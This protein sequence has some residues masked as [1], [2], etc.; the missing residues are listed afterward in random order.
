MIWLH[1]QKSPRPGKTTRQQGFSYS[2]REVDLVN[3]LPVHFISHLGSFLV[4]FLSPRVPPRSQLSSSSARG[5]PCVL[6]YSHTE[7]LAIVLVPV[8]FD[9]DILILTS[10]EHPH[11]DPAC[12]SLVCGARMPSL[13]LCSLIP[14]SVANQNQCRNHPVPSAQLSCHLIRKLLIDMNVTSSPE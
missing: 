14:R 11:Q 3:L 7:S 2:R 1:N 5:L 9:S 4:I 8:F 6:P 12:D 10:L 13:S